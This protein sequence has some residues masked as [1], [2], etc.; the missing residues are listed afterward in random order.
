MTAPNYTN[1][2]KSFAGKGQV[3]YY[4]NED[5]QLYFNDETAAYIWSQL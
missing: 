4:M 5:D 3:S 2:S 1:I